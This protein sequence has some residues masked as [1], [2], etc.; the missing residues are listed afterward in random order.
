MSSA[1]AALLHTGVI[2]AS[3]GLGIRR[4]CLRADITRVASI[5]R[6]PKESAVMRLRTA[7]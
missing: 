1:G 2:E 4:T 3:L 5:P 7:A 6:K